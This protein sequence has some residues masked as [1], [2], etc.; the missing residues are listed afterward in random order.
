MSFENWLLDLSKVRSF[1]S[2]FL[3]G[4]LGKKP[5]SN[6]HSKFQYHSA[7]HEGT[8][9]G[10]KKNWKRAKKDHSSFRD[11]LPCFSVLYT[12]NGE[13]SWNITHEVS[14]NELIPGK[15]G[16]GLGLNLLRPWRQYISECFLRCPIIYS[17]Q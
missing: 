5:E 17:V 10:D 1:R 14:N 13:E 2:D 15:S 3:G 6:I 4:V 16:E 11:T 8:Q 7:Y 12:N 9:G